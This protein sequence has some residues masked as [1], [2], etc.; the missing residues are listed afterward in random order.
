MQSG[1]NLPAFQRY[2]L[3]NIIIRAIRK[4]HTK[5]GLEIQEPVIQGRTSTRPV[6]NK[7]RIRQGQG[8][9]WERR[10]IPQNNGVRTFKRE[11]K[12]ED[13]ET[14][15]I[16]FPPSTLISSCLAIF[17]PI[18]KRPLQ[19]LFPLPPPPLSLAG[20]PVIMLMA[21]LM[22]HSKYN[23]KWVLLYMLVT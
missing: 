9:Q 10:G 6:G 5:N 16:L 13:K 18:P 11:R 12:K 14:F 23:R 4:M 8:S 3:P 21:V 15:F 17:P 7:V 22:L 19:G 20:K 2:L 1:R